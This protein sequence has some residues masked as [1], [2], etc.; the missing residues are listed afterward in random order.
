MSHVMDHPFIS[1]EQRWEAVVVRDPSAGSA[2]IYGVRTT[3]VYCRPT[4]SSRRPN[5]GNV[6]FFSTWRQAEA[7][8]F[9]ACKRCCPRGERTPEHAAVLAACRH[10]EACDEPPSLAEIASR[11]GLSPSYFHRLF[12]R[13]TGVTPKAY[14]GA[15]QTERLRNGLKTARTVTEAVHQAGLGSSS[16]CYENAVQ[17]LGMTP[18]DYRRDGAGQT[19]RYAVTP[20]HLGWMLVAATNIGICLIEFADTAEELS[21]RVDFR[22]PAAEIRADD[23]GFQ[24]MVKQVL[25][26]IEAPQ[27]GL[28][29]PLDIQGTA[30]QTRVWKALQAISAGETRTYTQ[31][32][33]SIGQPTAAR[34]VA[35]ACAA[36]KLAVA[37]PCHR[38]IRGNGDLS[39][40]RWGLDRKERLLRRESESN[41]QNVKDRIKRKPPTSE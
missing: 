41:R 35:G 15:R 26:F 9:R 17:N 40:Y 29:L 6:A 36:N 18:G 11:V 39:G 13:V 28:N 38:V 22:F 12:F 5:R 16:R 24:A 14:A 20:C 7:A 25:T 23:E 1:E 2:F 31:I 21:G 32:A 8:G 30:F 19:I 33:T 34:A 3:G 37:I 10:I 4:C 27:A